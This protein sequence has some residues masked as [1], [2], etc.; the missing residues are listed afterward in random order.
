MH[1]IGMVDGRGVGLICS[2]VDCN[3]DSPHSN[4]NDE[5]GPC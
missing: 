1:E 3:Q 5:L 4:G 2:L